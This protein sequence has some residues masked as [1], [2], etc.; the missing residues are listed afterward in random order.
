MIELFLN[1]A[2]SIGLLFFFIAFLGIAV[3]ALK[4]SNKARLQSLSYIPLQED[5]DG[6]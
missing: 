2:P 4:P 1:H 5:S 6:R 3:W